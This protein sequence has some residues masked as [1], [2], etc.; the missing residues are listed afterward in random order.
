MSNMSATLD[1]MIVL[2]TRLAYLLFLL[3]NP[4]AALDDRPAEGDPI[5]EVVEG[6][7]LDGKIDT[8]R[9]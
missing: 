8:E 5:E 9:G 7:D 3:L 6:R 4:I 2:A 1:S